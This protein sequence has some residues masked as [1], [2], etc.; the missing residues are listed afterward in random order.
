MWLQKKIVIKKKPRG[1]HLITSEIINEVPEINK[2]ISGLF[3]LFILHTSASITINENTDK[4][5]REDLESFFN[6]I[7]P[8]NE[9]Y[10]ETI[11]IT[12]ND[13][14]VEKYLSGKINYI[15]IHKN[16][17]Y[18]IQCVYFK[19]FFK[20]KPLNIK[21]VKNMITITNLYLNNNIKYYE[22]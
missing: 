8:E 20:E 19:K 6:K 7:V 9:S 21:D 12:L 10:F 15:S 1:F 11:L 2:I 4:T 18:F 22:K 3:H 5:V 13:N 17:L 14:L 16:L